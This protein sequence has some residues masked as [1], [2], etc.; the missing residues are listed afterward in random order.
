MKVKFMYEPDF[1]FLVTGCDDIG[2]ARTAVLD[3][4]REDIEDQFYDP[5]P[6]EEWFN[7]HPGRVEV[8]RVFNCQGHDPYGQG[9]SWYWMPCKPGRGAF[10]AVVFDYV[11]QP[12][13]SSH[14]EPTEEDNRG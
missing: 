6:A 13:T 2:K 1:S 11:P 7:T 8:G 10:K 9:C 3:E 12:K 5:T 14:P 4:H